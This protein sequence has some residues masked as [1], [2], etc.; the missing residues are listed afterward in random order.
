MLRIIV[1]ARFN[2]SSWGSV[3]WVALSSTIC[4]TSFFVSS[5]FDTILFGWLRLL[6]ASNAIPGMSCSR[7]WISHFCFSC[8]FSQRVDTFLFYHIFISLTG[9][10]FRGGVTR[11]A[12][13]TTTN[14]NNKLT[15]WTIRIPRQ[16]LK[17]P[18]AITNKYYK[19]HIRN[20][21][22]RVTKRN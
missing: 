16:D 7:C 14:N 8:T 19:S 15:P 9:Q 20:P 22:E 17:D 18:R 13:Q 11:K 10:R 6:F 3:A 4:I 5:S 2:I 1:E 12:L 21:R